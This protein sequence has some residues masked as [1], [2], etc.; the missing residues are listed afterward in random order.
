MTS[1]QRTARD[2]AEALIPLQQ[3]LRARR[4]LSPGK[5]SVL[6]HL[7]AHKTAAISELAAVAQVSPQA[8]SLSVRELEDMGHVARVPDAADRRRVG[9]TLTD[10]GRERLAAEM[11]AGYGWLAGAIEER[12]SPDEVSALESVLPVLRKLTAEPLDD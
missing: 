8:T 10:A 4:T 9:I 1:A 12:L 11:R 6:A 5:L 3:R 7:A 2:F